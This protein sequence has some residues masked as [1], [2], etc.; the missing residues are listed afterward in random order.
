MIATVSFESATAVEDGGEVWEVPVE[1]DVLRIGSA[2]RIRSGLGK[3][4][5][6]SCYLYI[7]SL[8]AL[9]RDKRNNIHSFYLIIVGVTSTL[10]VS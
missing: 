3:L 8:M 7:K 9:Y 5:Q 2:N 6:G 10:H 4:M 1:V